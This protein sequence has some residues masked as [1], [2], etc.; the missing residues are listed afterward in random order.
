MTTTVLPP[1]PSNIASLTVAPL[2][3]IMLNWCLYGAL[4]VQIYLY[5]QY[6][7]GDRR[8][9]Q[10][11][12]YG[13]YILE[14]VQT[15]LCTADAMRWYAIGYGDLLALIRPEFS[16][17]D[18]P[19]LDALIAIIVQLTFCW[20]IMV[21][22]KSW[23]I[24]GSIALVAVAQLVGALASAILIQEL[25]DLSKMRTLSFW[26]ALW[27]GGSALA[28]TLIATAMIILLLHRSSGAEASKDMVTRIIKLTVETNSVTAI[29]A[30]VGFV[31]TLTNPGDNYNM[32][33]SY[34]LGK[35]YSNTLLV[36]FNN[37]IF[38][39]R[40]RENSGPDASG[41]EFQTGTCAAPRFTQTS[42]G[43]NKYMIEIHKETAV[44]YD[45]DL[46]LDVNSKGSHAGSSLTP[47]SPV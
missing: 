22:S 37:R 47:D 24:S 30:I 12:V 20:R 40:A 5:S 6:F 1:I 43:P 7:K 25:Q 13:L 28:D 35:L 4:T 21:L 23:W 38:L 42:P 27:F 11:L 31:L 18:A 32:T 36:V 45:H 16:T 15:A 46:E 19:I 17:I 29:V 44:E 41:F 10:A 33:P 9:I 14:T 26:V 39:A 34:V 2:L 3:G 8:W